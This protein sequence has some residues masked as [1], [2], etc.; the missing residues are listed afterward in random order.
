MSAKQNEGVKDDAPLDLLWATAG[1]FNMPRYQM[2]HWKRSPIRMPNESYP[3][4][5]SNNSKR[6]FDLVVIG[7]INADLILRGDVMP[8]FGQV[9][10][11]IDDATLTMG[12]SGVIFACGA[13]RLGLKVAYIGKAG[14]DEFGRFM[15]HEMDTYGI[16][17]HGVVIDP[18][19]KTGLSVILSQG[20]D[21][22]ILTYLGT[23]AELTYQQIEF[24]ILDRARHLHLSSYYLLDE[25]RADVPQLFETAKKRGLTTS[26]DTNY[27][28]SEEWQGH[29]MDTLAYTDI[30]LPNETEFFGI[31]KANDLETGLQTLRNVVPMVAIKRGEQ[32]ALIQHGAVSASIPGI[33]V[34]PIDTTGAGD[35][36]DSGFIYG[37][38]S[39]WPIERAARFGCICGALSTQAAGGTD[40]QPSLAEVLKHLGR[41][42]DTA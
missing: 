16:D 29:I 6:E 31:T 11:L 20:N 2:M 25:L 33:G 8:T 22:A 15:L 24:S 40:A 9:E 34:D 5:R 41:S 17:T 18:N 19:I 30:F 35:S 1:E 13:A 14:D 27:D 21:R 26:I 4:W 12:S 23:I 38:L 32:G 42:Y 10:K 37:F 28:P 36:F 7:E 39:G 3:D